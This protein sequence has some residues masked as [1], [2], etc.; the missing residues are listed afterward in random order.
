MLPGAV[1]GG[2]QASGQIL[3]DLECAFEVQVHQICEL[4]TVPW[5]G[6]A[7]GRFAEAPGSRRRPADLT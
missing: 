1:E 7:G 4:K 5:G 6:L 3:V 2:G